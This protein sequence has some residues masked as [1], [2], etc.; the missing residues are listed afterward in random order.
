MT[1]YVKA[2][3][4]IW[5]DLMQVGEKTLHSLNLFYATVTTYNNGV[6]AY[7]ASEDVSSAFVRHCRN[8]SNIP[9]TLGR[10]GLLGLP[11]VTPAHSDNMISCCYDVFSA[12]DSRY[13]LVTQP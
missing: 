8:I 12:R 6:R 9:T 13:R 4:R 7:S 11:C 2:G 3:K 5:F 1:N 10:H